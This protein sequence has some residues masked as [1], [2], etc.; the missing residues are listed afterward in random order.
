MRISGGGKGGL[1]LMEIMIMLLFFGVSAAICMR[2]F[3][4]A[5]EGAEESRAISMA[6]IKAQSAAEAYKATGELSETARLLSGELSGENEIFIYYDSEWEHT[7]KENAEYILLLTQSEG[8]R[9]DIEV[10]E[11]E[12]FES[13]ESGKREKEPV[14]EIGVK[15]VGHVE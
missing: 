10:F 14:F 1:F 7:D 4:F 6:S 5:H 13:E 2:V 12:V 8:K 3:A 11:S 15:A 9:A